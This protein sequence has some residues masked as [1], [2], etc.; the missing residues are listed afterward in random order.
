MSVVA[1]LR[2]RGDGDGVAEAASC[3]GSPLAVGSPLAEGQGLGGG[4]PLSL[5]RRLEGGVSVPAVADCFG[6]GRT[7]SPEETFLFGVGGRICRS[8]IE[9]AS[10]GVSDVAGETRA[11][12]VCR[13]SRGMAELA[14]YSKVKWL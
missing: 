12:L 14:H 4:V 10:D 13:V 7:S 11:R 6:G 9:L 2:R 3:R 1:G 8:S 5:W